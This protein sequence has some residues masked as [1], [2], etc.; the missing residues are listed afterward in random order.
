MK[1]DQ[2]TKNTDQCVKFFLVNKVLFHYQKKKLGPIKESNHQLIF[3]YTCWLVLFKCSGLEWRFHFWVGVAQPLRL[4]GNIREQC[5]LLWNVN[6]NVKFRNVR[7]YCERKNFN[8]IM[9]RQTEGQMNMY[10]RGGLLSCVFAAKNWW[11]FEM[12]LTF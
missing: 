12:L 7:Q 8:L 9:D 1:K 3:P 5:E 10:I 11:Y 2:S 4:L 6:V